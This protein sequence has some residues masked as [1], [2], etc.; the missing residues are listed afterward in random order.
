[1]LVVNR[2]RGGRECGLHRVSLRLARRAGPHGARAA[3]SHLTC[4][5]SCC[6][7]TCSCRSRGW[8]RSCCWNS[9]RHP[10]RRCR[11]PCCSSSCSCRSRGWC[12]SCCW[13]SSRRRRIHRWCPYRR[14]PYVV[15]IVVVLRHQLEGIVVTRSGRVIG[16][17]RRDENAHRSEGEGRDQQADRR[18]DDSIECRCS[19]HRTL[20]F[21]GAGI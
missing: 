17:R 10:S 1:M 5:S 12:R 9:S 16:Q 15:V 13:N 21:V 8:C 14:R 4:V 7:S 20:S 3:R 11:R 6:S 19:G 18:D 2:G